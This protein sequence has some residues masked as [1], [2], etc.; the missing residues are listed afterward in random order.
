MTA[1]NSLG[2]HANASSG[3]SATIVSLSM[4]RVSFRRNGFRGNHRRRY[5]RC[6]LLGRIGVA[7]RRR[8]TTGQHRDAGDQRRPGGDTEARRALDHALDP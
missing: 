1:A 7:V 3:K 2:S 4:L 6:G 8:T 5:R